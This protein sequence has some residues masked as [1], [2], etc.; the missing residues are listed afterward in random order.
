MFA[1]DGLHHRSLY[2]ISAMNTRVVMSSTNARAL[3]LNEGVVEL[4]AR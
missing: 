3:A 1:P 2:Q 4:A